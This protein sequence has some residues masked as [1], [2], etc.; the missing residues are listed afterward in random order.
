VSTPRTPPSRTTRSSPRRACSRAVDFP[1]GWR[2]TPHKKSKTDPLK[3]PAVEKAVSDLRKA[4]KTEASSDDYE[5]GNDQYSSS[6]AV[7]R[8]ED[9]TRRVYKA[10]ASRDL[11]RC[12]SK[13][14][15]DEVAKQDQL[16]GLDVKVETGTV[17]GGSYGDESA[18]IGLK[19]TVSQGSIS[20]DVFADIVFVRVGRSLGFYSHVS[21]KE[22]STCDEFSPDDCV[23]FAGLITSATDRLVGSSA[24]VTT[25]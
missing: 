19:L 6:A 1:A 11:R 5:Q 12:V 21:D 14:F 8:T 15:K 24:P 3:C 18:N 4:K 13:L 25:T 16:K 17:T 23:S 20:Q 7:F 9:V 10:V 22:T 2:A